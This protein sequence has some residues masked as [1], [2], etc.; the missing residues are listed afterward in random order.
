MLKKKEQMKTMFFIHSHYHV[1]HAR[2]GTLIF[3]WD[4]DQI[5]N[6]KFHVERRWEVS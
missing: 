3:F 4:K 5:E 1:C 2:F 6:M